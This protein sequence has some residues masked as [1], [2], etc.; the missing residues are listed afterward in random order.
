MVAMQRDERLMPFKT[1]SGDTLEIIYLEELTA[2]V[3]VCASGDLEL[4][5]LLV[6][7]HFEFDSR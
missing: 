5:M 3:C 7:T 2:E 1:K 6:L 4:L